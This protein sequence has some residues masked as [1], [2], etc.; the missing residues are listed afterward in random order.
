M[1][2]D[3]EVKAEI[4]LRH[5]HNDI[6]VRSYE[7]GDLSF[8]ADGAQHFVYLYPHQVKLLKAFLADLEVE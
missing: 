6:K 7:D 1:A 2:L 5:A 4:E 8:S 3:N